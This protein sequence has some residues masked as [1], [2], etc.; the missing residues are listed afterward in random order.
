MPDQECQFKV[1]KSTERFIKL[2]NVAHPKY[3]LAIFCDKIGTTVG[4]SN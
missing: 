1:I 3:Y 4:N 2:Q